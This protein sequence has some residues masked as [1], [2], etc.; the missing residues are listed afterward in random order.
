[1]SEQIHQLTKYGVVKFEGTHNECWAKLLK[2]QPQSTDYA[3]K[4][5][6]WKIEPLK[7][8]TPKEQALTIADIVSEHISALSDSYDVGHT[9][10]QP[11]VIRHLEKQVQIHQ[12][13]IDLKK[14]VESL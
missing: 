12:L 1:M 13:L 8:S 11:E 2:M 5:G 9:I 4:Y 7:E 14:R 6:G 10:T 3:I